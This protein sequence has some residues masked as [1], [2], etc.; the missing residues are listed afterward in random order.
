MIK[1]PRY[2]SIFFIINSILEDINS[3]EEFPNINISELIEISH[4][5]LDTGLVETIDGRT[6]YNHYYK[7]FNKE[8]DN[9]RK[10]I[11]IIRKK[12]KLETYLNEIK[13]KL[14]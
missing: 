4:S 3:S 8:L 10:D 13:N 1:P 14:C 7:V 9:L 5:F 11:P 2:F 12:D 6:Y